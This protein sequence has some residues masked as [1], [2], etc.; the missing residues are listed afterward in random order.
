M[1]KKMSAT[2][3]ALLF[4]SVLLLSACSQTAVIQQ[5]EN[6]EVIGDN[7]HKID[8][9]GVKSAYVDPDVDFSQYQKILIEPLDMSEV[10]IVQPSQ[11]RSYN[12]WELTDKDR[13]A[14][15]D[16][17][18]AQMNKYLA[19]KNAGESYQIVEQPGEGVLVINAA[20][21]AIAP[22][23][24]K[25]DIS[26]RGYSGRSRVF[27]EG[28]GAMSIAM[29]VT[30][31]KTEKQLIEFVDNRESLSD[32]MRRNNSVTNLFDVNYLFSFWARKLKSGLDELS[33]IA[34]K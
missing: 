15:A 30:D 17:Y 26:S 2:P 19:E 11:S 4:S 20:V 27:T 9:S 5:G 22:S 28:A 8:N 29:L 32:R 21:L 23:A 34:N 16:S 12:K 31:G 13:K 18:M 7:L 33:Q 6:A 1:M 3:F 10:K 14:L 25:D 24:P